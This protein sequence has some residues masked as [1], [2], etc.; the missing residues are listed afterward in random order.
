M[1][2]RTGGEEPGRAIWCR[3]MAGNRSADD[4]RADGR[5][6]ERAARCGVH[7][8]N[9]LLSFPCRY[10]IRKNLELCELGT[11]IA[12]IPGTSR[13]GRRL[14]GFTHQRT[15]GRRRRANYRRTLDAGRGFTVSARTS[16]RGYGSRRLVPVFV[17]TISPR[18]RTRNTYG[19][20]A[21]TPAHKLAG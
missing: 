11:P 6:N 1:G 21:H 13:R 4:G 7:S 16:L 2:S 17:R 18:S 19:K 10:N 8:N 12:S 9:K 3:S 5:A 14:M 15:T 20:H